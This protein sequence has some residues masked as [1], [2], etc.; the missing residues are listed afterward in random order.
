[1]KE[2]FHYKK[3]MGQNFI[4]DP[5]LIER[6]AEASGVTREDGV[7]EIG[8]G[9][10]LLTA[11]LAR[12]AR[13]VIA[14]EL[15]RTLLRDLEVSMALYPNVEIVPGDIL[16]TDIGEI[17]ARLGSPC[18]VAANLPYNI[19]TPLL[20][21]LLRGDLPFVSIAVMVQREVGARMTAAP[22]AEGYGPFTLLVQYRATAEEAVRVPGACFTPP[23]KVDSS[24]MVLG[25]RQTPA[26]AVRDEALLF[27][28]IRASFAMRRKTMLNNLM[29]GFALPREAAAAL[30][31]GCAIAPE[32]RAE[33]LGLA[34]FARLADALGEAAR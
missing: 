33:R 30:L 10:G 22:G 18:R 6:L 25:M 31:A 24:F 1:M 20:E 4:F 3:E 19:T 12:R 32:T 13:Q 2:R 21:E 5:A 29:A 17:A 15:D 27:R 11:A 14:V 7:L 34:D 9:R 26:V 23:P 28:T 8:P 16:R